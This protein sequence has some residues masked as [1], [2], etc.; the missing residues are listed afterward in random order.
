MEKTTK[1]KWKYTD[2]LLSKQSDPSHVRKQ[3][4]PL[5]SHSFPSHAHYT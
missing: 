3:D 2:L 4:P 5:S 1:K